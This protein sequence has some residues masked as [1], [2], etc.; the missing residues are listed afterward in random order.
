[1]SMARRQEPIRTEAFVHIG[2]QLVN[3]DTLSREQRSYIGAKLRTAMLNAAWEGKAVFRAEGLPEQLPGREE[4]T[5]GK[6]KT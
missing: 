4:I 2:D 5:E 3:L 6:G 1:M